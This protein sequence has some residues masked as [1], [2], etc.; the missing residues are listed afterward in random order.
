M[1]FKDLG[2][3]AELGGLKLPIQGKEYVLPAVSA[4]LGPRLQ[5]VVSLGVAVHQGGTPSDSDREVLD[6]AGERD[7]YR[8]ILHPCE[9]DDI[10]CPPHEATERCPRDVY[11]EMVDDGVPWAALKHAAMTSM[12]DAVFDRDTAEK[13]WESAGKAPAPNRAQRRASKPTA[14]A[15]KAKKPASTG[16]TTSRRNTSGKGKATGGKKSSTTGR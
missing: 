6:D 4:E 13:H 16:T 1:A 12:F 5:A 8:E 9:P 7:L 2:D 3:W 15:I 14:Q 11:Q 10:E